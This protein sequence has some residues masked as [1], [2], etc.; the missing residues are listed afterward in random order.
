MD[1][2]LT[3]DGPSLP[4]A[5]GAAPKEIV[6]L[7][8]GVGADGN[9]LIGLAPYFQEI[10]PDALFISPNAPYRYDKAPSGYQWFSLRDYSDGA[11]LE[12]AKAAAPILNRFIDAT[13]AA[14]DLSEENM[15]L[16]G[17]SQG[18]MMALHVGLRRK[19]ALAGIVGYSGM[20]VGAD[21]LANEICSRPPVLMTHGDY[22]TVLPPQALHAAEVALKTAGIS[23]RAVMRPGLAHGI[24]EICIQLGKQFLAETFGVS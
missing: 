24:D 11:R 9:D 6:L 20:L 8:H 7:L 14:N 4:P 19:R 17:F 12:G 5:S 15:V 3:I 2:Q 13:L 23:V 21:V 16:I 1:Q 22:D 18:C 10:L